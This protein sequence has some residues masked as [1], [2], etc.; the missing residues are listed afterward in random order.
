M[1]FPFVWIKRSFLCEEWLVIFGWAPYYLSDTG[2]TMTYELNFV[3]LNKS[4]NLQSLTWL[5]NNGL[6]CIGFFY[7]LLLF[8]SDKHLLVWE[9]LQKV[10]LLSFLS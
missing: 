7:F 10:L 2:V 9:I 6:V 8:T 3:S 1:L 4:S 5:I